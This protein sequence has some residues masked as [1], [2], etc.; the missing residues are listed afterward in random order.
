M[1]LTTVENIT[2]LLA[3][4]MVLLVWYAKGMPDAGVIG[5][6]ISTYVIAWVLGYIV[7]GASGGIGIREAALLILLGPLLG[8]SLVSALA[9]VHRLITIIG[10]F[11]GYLIV[12]LQE[13]KKE[14][15]E[16]HA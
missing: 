4:V 2:M 7:P 1:S 5:T 11:L 10:D 16:K 15:A 8:G 3:A 6:V 13:R 9:L 14:G 12:I